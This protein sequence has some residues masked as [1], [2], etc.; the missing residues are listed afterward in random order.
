MTAVVAG[1]AH[2]VRR[3]V[4]GALGGRGGS[5]EQVLFI[6]KNLD[7]D[8]ITEGFLACAVKDSDTLRFAVGGR[9]QCRVDNRW[10]AGEVV[11]LWDEGN[12]YRV[13]LDQGDE[14]WAAEDTQRLIRAAPAGP[15]LA[16]RKRGREGKK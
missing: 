11:K 8:T 6:G 1:R 12:P 15:A 2:D 7:R 16:G 4:R 13:K 14:V 9:V 3:G 5:G 10:A